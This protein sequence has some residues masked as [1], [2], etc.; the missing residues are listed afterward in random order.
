MHSDILFLTGGTPDL[1][2]Q[3]VKE[4]N[5]TEVIKRFDGIVIGCSAGARVQCSLFHITPNVKYPVF[6][7]DPGIGLLPKQYGV[8]VHYMLG[9]YHDYY[10]RKTVFQT[11]R[12]TLIMDNFS[13]AIFCNQ[14]RKFIGNADIFNT[15]ATDKENIS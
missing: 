13:A 6:Y 12:Q 8:A 3:R 9:S 5:L 1:T 4:R 7:H 11:H 10:L 14:K 2:M 15:S